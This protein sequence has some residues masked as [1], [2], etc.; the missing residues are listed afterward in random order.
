MDSFFGSLPLLGDLKLLLSLKLWMVSDWSGKE[1]IETSSS[2]VGIKSSSFNLLSFSLSLISLLSLDFYALSLVISS[3]CILISTSFFLFSSSRTVTFYLEKSYDFSRFWILAFSYLTTSES[4]EFV[5]WLCFKLGVAGFFSDCIL[6]LLIM[7]LSAYSSFLLR[8][9][10]YL[11]TLT[12][13]ALH[14]F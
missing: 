1:M 3:W 9:A 2:L 10:N 4:L 8:L 5:F 13:Y 6:I 14:K 7:F 12:S 11:L